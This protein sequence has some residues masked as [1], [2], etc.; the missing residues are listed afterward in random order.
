MAGLKLDFTF[1]RTSS[2]RL[3]KKGLIPCK[4]SLETW[5]VTWVF[6]LDGHYLVSLIASLHCTKELGA[7]YFLSSIYRS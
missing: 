2:R 5:V 3:N 7:T 1:K 4:V 6:L